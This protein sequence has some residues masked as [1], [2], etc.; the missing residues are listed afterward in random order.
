[1]AGPEPIGARGRRCNASVG[2]ATRRPRGVSK[3]ASSPCPSLGLRPGGQ[4][5]SARALPARRTVRAVR[6]RVPRAAA[7][8]DLRVPGRCAAARHVK[9]VLGAAR[10]RP[11]HAGPQCRVASPVR[12][13]LPHL[14]AACGPRRP[15][16]IRV[17]RDGSL[18]DDSR[19][20]RG[21]QPAVP[22]CPRAQSRH[23]LTAADPVRLSL[24][25]ISVLPRR[26]A[27]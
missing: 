9:P 14:P 19:A 11:R 4:F 16:S 15:D 5:R 12:H 22:A 18:P 2:C 7:R 24:G 25:A 26:T 8:R 23:A 17:Q 21:R 10:V 20:A 13:V 3:S 27:G 1:M 6:R